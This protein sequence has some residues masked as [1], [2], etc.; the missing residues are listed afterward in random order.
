MFVLEE[1]LST[2]LPQPDAYRWVHVCDYT[3][4]ADAVNMAEHA[5]GRGRIFRIREVSDFVRWCSVPGLA[6]TERYNVWLREL[7]TSVDDDC[8]VY[9]IS[10]DTF[11]EAVAHVQWNLNEYLADAQASDPQNW[12]IDNADGVT[13]PHWCVRTRT[14]ADE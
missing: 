10:V 6:R 12:H 5:T 1:G 11:E 7:G 14:D 4:Y 8:F 2:A 3:N 13:I 9:D